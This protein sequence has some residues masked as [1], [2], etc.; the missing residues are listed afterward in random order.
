M[1]IDLSKVT[2]VVTRPVG[3]G[4]G[5]VPVQ[6]SGSSLVEQLTQADAVAGVLT[7]AAAVEY[8]EIYNRDAVNDGVFTVNGVA[9]TVPK[10]EVWGG[11]VGG[12]PSATVTVATSTSYIVSRLT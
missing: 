7:F 1:A 3:D 11:K 5:P 9:V 8:V 4:G 12:A 10:G 6:L 2:S